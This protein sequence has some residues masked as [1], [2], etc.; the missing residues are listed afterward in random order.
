MLAFILFV[1]IKKDRPVYEE[2]SAF[3]DRDGHAVSGLHKY[4]QYG[5]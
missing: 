1:P 5:S 4:Q 3:M 2:V